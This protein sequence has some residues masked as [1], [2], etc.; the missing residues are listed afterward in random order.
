MIFHFSET[1]AH[2]F[3]MFFE[4]EIEA[5]RAFAKT[6]PGVSLFLID[7]FDDIAGAEK[8]AIVA[9]ELESEGHRLIGVRIDSGDL[10]EQSKKV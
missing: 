1:M 6:F 9:K 8:A 2:S 5:F 3:V 4:K 7:T 10:V